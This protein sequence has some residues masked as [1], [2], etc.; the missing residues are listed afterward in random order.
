VKFY[1]SNE[2]EAI[3]EFI[4]DKCIDGIPFETNDDSTPEPSQVE[5]ETQRSK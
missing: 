1:E 5:G 4:Y 3:K 2:I